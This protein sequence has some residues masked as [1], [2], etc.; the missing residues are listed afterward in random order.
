MSK[1]LVT[2]KEDCP[3]PIPLDDMKLGAIPEEPLA[4]FLQHH[5]FNSLLKRIGQVADTAKANKAIAGNPKAT[6]RGDGAASAPV[7][8]NAAKPPLM[9]PIDTKNYEC[10]TD[11]ARLDHWIAR[12]HETGLLGFDTETDSLQAASAN[13]VGFSLAV[14]AWARPVISRSRTWRHRYVR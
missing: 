1:I 5:G 2:L 11:L 9:P 8:G 12:A 6:S 7:A 10:V 14:A 3:L 13:L 4:A